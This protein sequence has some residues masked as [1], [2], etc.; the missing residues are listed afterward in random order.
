MGGAPGA[1]AVPP[2]RVVP[3]RMSAY[4][5]ASK[6]VFEVFERHGA[7]GRGALDRRGVP[8]RPRARAHLRNAG[9]DRRAAAARGPR[10][11]RAADHASGVARTKFLAKV[12]SAVAKPDG[13]LVVPPERELEFLH[14]LPVE[15]LW[16]VGRV[17][18]AKLRE[19]GIDDRRARSPS[20]TRRALVAMLGRAA[21]RQLHALAHNRDPRPV[22][23]RAAAPVDRG[24]ARARARTA[25]ARGARGGADDP[26]RPRHSPDARGPARVPDGRAAAAVRRLLPRDPF[27]HDARADR[28]A[29]TRSSRAATGLLTTVDA[30]DRASRADADR[31]SR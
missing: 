14:P 1:A 10:R 26:R 31:R 24:P 18:A 3:P 25:A 22:R 28:S 30:A 20:S 29:R 13:L 15:R 4:S 11:G 17:T 8:R 12:A 27:A 2:R 23:T 6:A 7:G 9:R 19:R 21:G 16:G 5:E